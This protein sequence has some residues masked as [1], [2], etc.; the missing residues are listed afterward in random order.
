MALLWVFKLN[1][2]YHFDWWEIIPLF[3]IAPYKIET[4]CIVAWFFN[5]FFS[6]SFS[7]AKS[8][9]YFQEIRKKITIDRQLERNVFFD[10]FSIAFERLHHGLQ[11]VQSDVP[12]SWRLDLQKHDTVLLAHVHV[13][14]LVLLFYFVTAQLQN[15]LAWK[16]SVVIF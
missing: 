6:L 15:G 14:P 13:V 7:Q 12:H 9:P 3:T 2:K 16:N 4:K 5:R 11:L 10:L 8:D 1:C